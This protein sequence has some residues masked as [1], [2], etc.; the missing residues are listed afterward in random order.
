MVVVDARLLVVLI[1]RLG[2]HGAGLVGMLN[3]VPKAVKHEFGHPR[4]RASPRPRPLRPPGLLEG[5]RLANPNP[6]VD[7]EKLKVL[8]SELRGAKVSF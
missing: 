7:V 4:C 2:R 3:E 1:G 8:I 5:D 6:V